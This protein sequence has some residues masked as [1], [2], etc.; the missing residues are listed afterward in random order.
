MK[1]L[2]CRGLIV[3]TVKQENYVYDL[4]LLTDRMLDFYLYFAKCFY[5]IGVRV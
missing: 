3:Y 5:S 1:E 4:W 2:G